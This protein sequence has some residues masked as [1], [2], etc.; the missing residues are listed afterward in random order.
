MYIILVLLVCYSQE[1][2]QAQ[3]VN[4]P[5]LNFKTELVNNTAINTNGDNE[6]QVFE[7]QVFTGI[8][9]VSTKNIA[10]L[11][12]I[13]AFT[14]LTD[15]RCAYN[16]LTSI[17][18]S[19]NTALSILLCPYNQLTGLN[20]SS[21]S[22]LT[23]VDCG[24]NSISSLDLTNNTA[25]TELSCYN[26]QLTSLSFGSNT[27]LNELHC[28]NNLLTSLDVSNNAGLQFLYCDHNNI[29]SF[30]FTP[31]LIA[32]K[33]SNNQLT[34]LNIGGLQNLSTLD[35]ISNQLTNLDVSNQPNLY[36]LFCNNNAL[37][38]L[39]VSNNNSLNE[40]TCSHNQ[41]TTINASNGNN[42]NMQTFIA[43]FNPNL[44]CIQVDNVAYANANWS[45]F[46]S[47]SANFSTNCFTGIKQVQNLITAKVFPNPTSGYITVQIDK[48]YD[49]V[50]II[51]RDIRGA[52]IQNQQVS[53]TN[54]V[55]L[56]LDVP[57]GLYLVNLIT[58]E[59]SN[60]IR[61]VKT[62]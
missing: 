42:S 50:Q 19:A 45:S 12:G 29:T 16:Q 22:N 28:N 59:G 6:I 32:L 9:N 26:N 61:I 30:V 52:V 13:E 31:S 2:I 20:L 7:A 40:L 21:N 47:S 1:S 37:T 35:C 57:D 38:F 24:F 4:I 41:L 44:T 5:D 62:Q 51:I 39:D 15:L 46:V 8:L 48:V 27:T 14:A 56:E 54:Q 55:E 25:L 33:C 10:D 36:R 60:N 23:I 17:D 34:S 18:L 53:N 58:A 49:N 43:E 11:T 3:I